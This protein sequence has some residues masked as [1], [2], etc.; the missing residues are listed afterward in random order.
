MTTSEGQITQLAHPPLQLFSQRADI[1]A[2]PQ[3]ARRSRPARRFFGVL[4][5]LVACGDVA[6]ATAVAD[7]RFGLPVLPESARGP[8]LGYGAFLLA[9]AIYCVATSFGRR[10]SRA[11]QPVTAIAAL[12]EPFVVRDGEER[13][14]MHALRQNG[15]Y[16]ADDVA[17]PHVE[18]DHVAVG[19]AGVLAVQ[20]MFTDRPDERG[21]AAVRARIGAAELRK[22]LARRELHVDVVPAVLAFGPGLTEE[23]GGVKVVDS[24]AILF[25]DQAAAWIGELS[26]RQLLDQHVVEA[27]R[28]VIGDVRENEE[29]AVEDRVFVRS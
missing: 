27:V 11:D 23:P 16:V 12:T 3:T 21:K 20:V 9:T 10:Q 1:Q 18:V 19:P 6:V 4:A 17:L 22:L 24:V 26:R 7:N 8:L 2:M 13:K 14:V 5:G 15:W 29:T 28:M 25:G